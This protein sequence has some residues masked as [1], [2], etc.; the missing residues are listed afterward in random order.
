M[1]TA[2]CGVYCK[3]SL[4]RL[5]D[6]RIYAALGRYD[7]GLAGT[8]LGIR[9]GKYTGGRL[10]NYVPEDEPDQEQF[11]DGLLPEVLR[12][13]EQIRNLS[14]EQELEPFELAVRL[15][16]EKEALWKPEQA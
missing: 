2:L 8:V 9:D 13:M 11:I 3:D 5:E 6:R 10:E 1:L 7:L 12:V 14:E 15:E 16:K 4:L